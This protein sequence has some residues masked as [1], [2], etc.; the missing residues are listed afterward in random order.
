MFIETERLIIRSL[1]PG[2]AESYIEM[3]A[4]GSLQ[5]IFGIVQIAGNG[6]SPG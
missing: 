5:D 2:D 1:E 3:A 4:D 6:W